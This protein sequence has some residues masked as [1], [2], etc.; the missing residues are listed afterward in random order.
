[1]FSFYRIGATN[2]LI[3]NTKCTHFYYFCENFHTKTMAQL[4]TKRDIRALALLLPLLVVLV[5]VVV[6]ALNSGPSKHSD[7]PTSEDVFAQADSIQQ[8]LSLSPFDPNTVTYEELREMNVDKFVARNIVKYRS[9]GRTF[10]IPEDVAIVYGISDSLY[11]QLK[12]YIR[13]GAKYLPQPKTYASDT[14]T[15]E[16]F[17]RKSRAF[18]RIPFDPNTLD[19]EGFYGLGCFTARQAEAMVEYRQ[20]LGGFR[21]LL[22]FADCYLISDTLYAAM[23]EFITLSPIPEPEKVLVDINSADSTTLVALPGIGPASAVDIILY[24][25][26][27]GGYHSTEQLKD[28]AV[29]MDKNYDRFVKE[30]WC[31][32][33][34]IQKIDINFVAP[35]ELARHPY[36][37][38]TRMRKI[39]KQ[40]QKRGGW[41][42]IEEM[43]KDKIFTEEE[44]ARISPYLQFNPVEK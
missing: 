28:L 30:I 8:A 26:K 38:A 4:F 10:S 7:T 23:E 15:G 5:W 43:V 39:L 19:A 17:T 41:S 22:E 6:E 27:L 34:K 37:T 42:T 33:C 40:R 31:D 32:S 44:A 2:I 36:M 1:M 29:I 9:T 12:P 11:A 35:K 21:S 3:Y 14:L 25:E 24:R 18:K 20:R 13:I 16:R